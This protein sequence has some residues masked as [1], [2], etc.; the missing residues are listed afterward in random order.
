MSH[1]EY[2][3]E[4]V[5]LDNTNADMVACI[6]LAT[7]PDYMNHWHDIDV[8]DQTLVRADVERYSFLARGST[9]LGFCVAFLDNQP[10]EPKSLYICDVVVLPGAQ[11]RGYGTLMA[12]E[13]MRRAAEDNIETINFTA[14]ERTTYQILS[15]S[16][17]VD[18]IIH[19]MGYQLVSQNETICFPDDGSEP[20]E[21]SHLFSLVRSTKQ[22]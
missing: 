1:G 10:D 22:G 3:V 2:P 18:E 7:Y 11:K 4:F 14:R 15:Y 13:V 17:N 5:P 21:R 9:W 6:D 19:D 16:K 20:I 12:M 8:L